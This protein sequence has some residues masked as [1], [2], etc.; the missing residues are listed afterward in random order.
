MPPRNNNLLQLLNNGVQR[1]DR[2]DRPARPDRSIPSDNTNV[3][4]PSQYQIRQVREKEALRTMATIDAGRQITGNPNLPP[5]EAINAYNRAVA[6]SQMQPDQLYDTNKLYPAG[7]PQ[8]FSDNTR[9]ALGYYT[10]AERDLAARLNQARSASLFGGVMPNF[11]SQWAWLNPQAEYDAFNTTSTYLPNALT[12]GATFGS[13]P[14][15]L[16]A[17]KQGWNAANVAGN[18]ANIGRQVLN[19]AARTGNA[20]RIAAATA[21]Q[22]ANIVKPLTFTTFGAIPVTMLGQEATD[23]PK[24]GFWAS[25]WDAVK[26]HPFITGAIGL[27]AIGW[28]VR[29]LASLGGA[30]KFRNWLSNLWYNNK[31]PMQENGNTVIYDRMRTPTRSGNTIFSVDELTQDPTR[32]FDP[33]GH[34]EFTF[35]PPSKDILFDPNWSFKQNSDWARKIADM[36]DDQIRDAVLKL[37]ENK[38]LNTRYLGLDT[39]PEATAL[40]NAEADLERAQSTYD[41]VQGYVNKYLLT[42]TDDATRASLQTDINLALRLTPENQLVGQ[43]AIDKAT[44]LRNEAQTAVN[45]AN[46][47]YT[48]LENPIIE[49]I[50]KAITQ[51]RNLAQGIIDYQDTY[52]RQANQ[53]LNNWRKNHSRWN[54]FSKR[55]T[56]GGVGSGVAGILDWL[57]FG[58]DNAGDS[59]KQTNTPTD[60]I[61]LGVEGL[62]DPLNT[63]NDQSSDTILADPLM[64]VLNNNQ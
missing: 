16:N 36:T 1:S 33:N 61:K 9:R 24:E 29:G 8:T 17:A 32:G 38:T 35:T 50:N 56:W 3:E 57:I 20:A 40:R 12:M 31:Y 52:T 2:P 4:T 58:N 42:D 26:E 13:S 45:N 6:I 62:G 19:L 18:T 7:N 60:S 22:G 10:V 47:A 15:L 28:G 55:L 30:P 49:E 44:Q 14:S 34:Y 48:N 23:S 46:T 53:M 59:Q 25:T 27:P 11:G 37:P 5:D 63:G 41:E 39:S 43:E 51:R 54:T 64:Q 21:V